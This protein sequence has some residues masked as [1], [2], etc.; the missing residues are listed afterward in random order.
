MVGD[1]RLG[2]AERLGQVADAGLAVFPGGDHG[3]QPQPGGVGQGF[4]QPG[5][6]GGLA[7]GDRLAQ[8]RRAARVGQREGWPGPGS[9]GAHLTSMHRILTSVYLYAML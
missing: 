7:G 4:E 6:L 3:D 8:Q 1:G 2:Q 9:G 5:Q